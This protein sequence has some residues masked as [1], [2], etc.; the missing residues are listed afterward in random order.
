VRAAVLLSA[1]PFYGEREPSRI[2]GPVQVPTLH[3]TATGDIIRIPGFYSGAE[4]RIAVF[5]AIGSRHKAL[6]VFEG[7]SHSMF[8][9]RSGTGGV[10]LNPRVK[11]ATKELSLA[12]M[13]TRLGV[14]S[15][16]ALSLWVER[17]RAIIAKH[18]GAFGVV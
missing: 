15:P 9:D 4:D 11:L 10:E 16:L 12:F 17:Y 6:A 2:L 5:N 14:G 7:G 1:P 18:D 13:Q 3:V 8:T